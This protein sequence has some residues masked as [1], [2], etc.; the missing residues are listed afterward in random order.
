MAYSTHRTQPALRP[1]RATPRAEDKPPQTRRPHSNGL[2][3]PL[4]QVT[5]DRNC[6]CSWRKVHRV[7]SVICVSPAPTS[8]ISR[9]HGDTTL[10]DGRHI[11]HRSKY[12]GTNPWG[13]ATHRSHIYLH[14]DTTRGDGRHTDHISN[15]T[16]TNPWER[17]THRSQI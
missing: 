9:S 1:H 5:P 13:R 17:A 15:Y 12:T 3:L 4:S 2:T 6:P 14:G 8:W 10:G 7:R 11:D 16:G